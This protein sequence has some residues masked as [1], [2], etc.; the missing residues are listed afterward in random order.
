VLTKN[1]AE[2]NIAIVSA[3]SN[4]TRNLS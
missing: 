4:K 1:N 3:N 2:N